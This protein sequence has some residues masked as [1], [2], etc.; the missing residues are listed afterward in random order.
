MVLYST[1][2]MLRTLVLSLSIIVVYF[3]GRD[4]NIAGLRDPVL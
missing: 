1:V 3:T 2:L 4:M